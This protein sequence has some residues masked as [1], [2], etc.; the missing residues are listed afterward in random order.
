M[1]KKVAKNAVVVEEKKR[2]K[3]GHIQDTAKIH[4]KSFE[5]MF[6]I[7]NSEDHSENLTLLDVVYNLQHLA[8]LQVS[9]DLNDRD[10]YAD[11]IHILNTAN[12]SKKMR[13]AI[14]HRV[15][16]GDSLKV[17]ASKLQISVPTLDRIIDRAL[18]LIDAYL[19]NR[20]S[21]A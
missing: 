18:S 14:L 16:C 17:T 8:E 13:L 2:K 11:V 10:T 4:G 12:L 5:M 9:Y 3:V 19:Q 1:S 6:H 7:V 15:V 21:E 20:N